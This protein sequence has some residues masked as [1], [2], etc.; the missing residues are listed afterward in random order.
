[1]P[2][3]LEA[4]AAPAEKQLQFF[5]F[6]AAD[7]GVFN[8]LPGWQQNKVTEARNY[9]TIKWDNSKHV[10]DTGDDWDTSEVDLAVDP[11]SERDRYLANQAAG[12]SPNPAA[13]GTNDAPW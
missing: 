10:V 1:M 12:G 8:S 7:I 11:L 13:D 4:S 3:A 6:D 2:A 5:D 9:G